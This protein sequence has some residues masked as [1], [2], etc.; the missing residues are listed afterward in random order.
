MIAEFLKSVAATVRGMTLGIR[1]ELD[2]PDLSKLKGKMKGAV[3]RGTNRAGKPVRAA[4]IANAEKIKRYGF[5]AKSIGNKARVYPN[6]ITL[7]IGPKMS[8]SRL[9]G[10]YKIGTKAGQK[11]RHVPYLYSWIVERGS[12]RSTPK[13]FLLRAWEAH[14]A[15]FMANVRREIAEELKKLNTK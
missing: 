12:K 8:F 10:K 4:V 5:L 15:E 3:L 9:K 2:L 11:K 6:A 1:C 7:V 14:Q 13:R